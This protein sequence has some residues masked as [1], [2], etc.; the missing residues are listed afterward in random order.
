MF[1]LLKA[2]M[3]RRVKDAFRAE[4]QAL[5][6]PQMIHGYQDASGQLRR[7]TRISDTAIVYH[8]EKVFIGDN[9]F[10]G[11]YNILDGTG[12]LEIGEGSQTAALVGIFTHGSHISIRL[13]GKHYQEVPEY[14][15]P[16]FQIAPVKVGKYVYVGAGAKIL[17]GVTIGNGALV[18]AGS[19]V[20][21]DVPGF[22][23]VRG[24]PAKIVGN[25]R[26]LDQP[27]LADERLRE[28]YQEWQQS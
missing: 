3:P 24:S 1:R 4:L 19:L 22:A 16:G 14:E 21:K 8:P 11:H 5:K 13:L 12:G 23:I 17:P 10:I 26:K 7:N 18:S 25:T 9:V 27:Y 6:K 15:K 2:I 20:V 28:W